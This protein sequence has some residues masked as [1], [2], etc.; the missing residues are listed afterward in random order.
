MH[1]FGRLSRTSRVG[2]CGCRLEQYRMHGQAPYRVQSHDY[3]SQGGLHDSN[4][5]PQPST[6]SPVYKTPCM[7]LHQSLAHQ[8]G[9]MLWHHSG[10]SGGCMSLGGRRREVHDVSICR[11]RGVLRHGRRRIFVRQRWRLLRQ[12]RLQHTCGYNKMASAVMHLHSA[13]CRAH[14]TTVHSMA[15]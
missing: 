8:A 15:F 1:G 12:G 14:I 2:C 6:C 13:S 3:N 5:K 4:T 11:R 9:A 7:Q 10:G